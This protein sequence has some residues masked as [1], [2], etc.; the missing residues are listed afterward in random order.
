MKIVL[1]ENIPHGIDASVHSTPEEAVARLTDPFATMH[2]IPDN[3]AV[4]GQ[5][6]NLL[7]YLEAQIE[8]GDCFH[9]RTAL[10][11]QK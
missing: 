4:Q 6:A 1:R 8:R 7:A 3:L 2:R 11:V 9:V 5:E 10:K